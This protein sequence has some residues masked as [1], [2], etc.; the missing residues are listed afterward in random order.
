M[1]LFT[2]DKTPKDKN[3]IS[4]GIILR[5]SAKT[6]N[7]PASYT[8]SRKGPSVSLAATQQINAETPSNK[9]VGRNINFLENF[10]NWTVSPVLNSIYKNDVK[11]PGIQLKE[12]RLLNSTL[13]EQI[14][15]FSFVFAT[16][17]ERTAETLRRGGKETW[18]TKAL[19]T[20]QAI[21]D[22]TYNTIAGALEGLGF[23]MPDTADQSSEDPYE[24]IYDYTETGFKY[25]LPYYTNKLKN[26]YNT[27]SDS[28]S[29]DG[30]G[31]LPGVINDF[32]G[33]VGTTLNTG[34]RATIEPGIYIEKTQF[35]NFGQDSDDISFA[36]PLLNTISSEQIN[37]NYQFLFL[38]IYQNSIYRKDRAAFIPPCIYEILVPGIRYM[39]YSYV[40]TLQID[41]I[42][43]RR[44]IEVD[45]G[46]SRF[47][48]IVPE[49]YNVKMSVAPL[50]AE[51]GNFLIRS[52]T[53]DI[54]N[55]K[56][57]DITNI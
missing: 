39:K 1:G 56:S 23:K 28:Y 11:L 22:V 10:K 15:Y 45:A 38:L 57:S 32:V 29:Q 41:F 50:H 27:F 24:G 13:W 16:Q 25:T 33:K 53:N 31:Y 44:M 4:Q 52:A 6:A 55:V 14:K 48:T 2:L 20:S 54:E 34:I 18:I 42:G 43:T 26:T 36:F 51:A 37:E 49:A 3:M 19:D 35:Y 7:D 47:K 21:Q 30:K 5:P 8:M 12:Y 40:K 46:I 9:I 17:S